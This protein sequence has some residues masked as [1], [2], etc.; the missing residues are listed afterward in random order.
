M[1]PEYLS[2]KNMNKFTPILAIETSDIICGACIYFDENKFFSS[3]IL[4]KHAHSEKL[5]ELIQSV[6][7]QADIQLSE[8]N[9]IAV[10]AG[11]GSFTGLRIGMAAAKGISQALSI[12]IIPVPTFE[13]LAFQISDYLPAGLSFIISNKVGKDELYFARF[14]IRSNNHIFQEELKI[15][16]NSELN[17]LS[18]GNIIFSNISKNRINE[19]L[20]IVPISAPDPDSVAKWASKFGQGKEVFEI[21]YLEPNYLKEFLVKEK[22]L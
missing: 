14:H 22:K 6:R 13:A 11:P 4:L 21:D 8:I 5:F 17:S 3:K 7:E 15:I 20:K 2:L 1:I 16:Q 12:P 9:S 10:S 18:E 19:E